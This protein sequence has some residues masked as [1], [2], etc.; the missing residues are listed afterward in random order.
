MNNITHIAIHHDPEGRCNYL[1]EAQ[2]ENLR[3]SFTDGFVVTTK[4]TYG[5]L[6]TRKLLEQAGF[7]IVVRN[8]LRAREVDTAAHIS[9]VA[10]Y[11]RGKGELL[12]FGCFDRTLHWLQT[13][14]EEFKQVLARGTQGND[15]LIIGRTERALAT[16]PRVQ[17]EPE[18]YTNK[19][20]ARLLGM[21]EVDVAGAC[22]MLTMEIAKEIVKFLFKENRFTNKSVDVA[23]SLWPYAAHLLGK[24]VG[25]IK[26]EG[27]EFETPD[28]FR[29]EIKALGYEEW[30]RRN[31]TQENV[32]RRMSRAQKTEQALHALSERYEKVIS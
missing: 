27:L 21:D 15:Y 29:K 3:S 7:Q 23:D 22:R 32:A 6:H 28:Q 17:L 31:F 13:Y 30:V 12:F 8:T 5:N 26:T 20:T 11:E 18:I 9:L 16:H 14:P 10:G 4:E 24:K 2:A 19:V 1:L 25:F